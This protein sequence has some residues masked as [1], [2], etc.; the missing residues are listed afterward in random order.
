MKQLQAFYDIKMS[1]I[2]DGIIFF[3]KD[4][5]YTVQGSSYMSFYKKF[6]E[7]HHQKLDW[8]DVASL[9]NR[10]QYILDQ[11]IWL[12]DPNELIPEINNLCESFSI[13]MNIIAPDGM[14]FGAHPIRGVTGFWQD[15]DA[16]VEKK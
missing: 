12:D 3:E 1:D 14:W 9:A 11:V 8:K 2:K 10:L 15:K 5:H 13:I 16:L 4:A 7:W 6:L